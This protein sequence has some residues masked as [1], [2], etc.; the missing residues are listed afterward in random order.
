MAKK[1]VRVYIFKVLLFNKSVIWF[2]Y[3]WSKQKFITLIFKG[4]NVQNPKNLFYKVQLN[5]MEVIKNCW[6]CLTQRVKYK[7]K[8]K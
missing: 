4:Q 8:L 2:L 6:L 5:I 7:N 3:T 1:I